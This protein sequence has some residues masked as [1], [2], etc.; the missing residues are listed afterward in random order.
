MITNLPYLLEVQACFILLWALFYAAIGRGSNFAFSRTYLL[1]LPVLSFVIP[2]LNIPVFVKYVY[3]GQVMPMGQL[4]A[5]FS[6]IMPVAEEMPR[7]GISF[8]DAAI[9]AATLGTIFFLFRFV[10]S[11]A[12]IRRM[13][14]KAKKITRNGI[15]LYDSDKCQSACSFFRNI[16]INTQ[17]MDP[18]YIDQIVAH[19]MTH[20][21]MR[22]SY[23]RVYAN[24]VHLLLWWNPVVWLWRRSLVEVHEY[25][26]D[27]KVL[28][29][30]YEKAQY[31]NL[32]IRELTDLH[33][34]F[35]SGFSYSLIKKRL[36]MISKRTS[37]RS[38]KLGILAAI[39]VVG[40]LMLLF[41]FTTRTEYINIV[42]NEKPS[43]RLESVEEGTGERKMYFRSL[44]DSTVSYNPATGERFLNVR[45]E[46]PREIL[47][48]KE[49][50]KLV[51]EV[52]GS[53]PQREASL[54]T[55]D[56][57]AFGD[58]IATL[59]RAKEKAL[60]NIDRHIQTVI[61]S[62]ADAEHIKAAVAEME[63]AKADISEQI[64]REQQQVMLQAEEHIRSSAE[65]QQSRKEMSNAQ[66]QPRTYVTE[67]Q[68]GTLRAAMADMDRQKEEMTRS[69]EQ[70][71]QDIISKAPNAEEAKKAAEEM[72]RAREEMNKS[73]E[74]ARQQMS[75]E[76]DG[77]LRF[78]VDESP[79]SHQKPSEVVRTA[80]VNTDQQ[81]RAVRAVNAA[82]DPQGEQTSQVNANDDRMT[83]KS[84]DS[85]QQQPQ[86]NQVVRD[87][88]KIVVVRN[89]NENSNQRAYRIVRDTD[90]D[91]QTNPQ[92]VPVLRVEEMPKF[93][94][95]GTSDFQKWVQARIKYPQEAV[96]NN[97][98]GAVTLSFVVNT[99]GEVVDVEVVSSPDSIL[100]EDAVRVVKSSPKWTPGMQRGKPQAVRLNIPILYEI[101]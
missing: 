83:V 44:S 27:R 36:T 40:G 78:T 64:S 23:D 25:Q 49:Y 46:E 3:L 37:G 58:A 71:R 47:T 54:N 13:S 1:L 39:P 34:E 85:G 16:Y 100:S 53:N 50:E 18:G 31:V 51:K 32:I 87:E 81:V 93:Q 7:N 74:E 62:N 63:K 98:Q 55:E 59:E 89:S 101:F 97:I 33:P 77:S 38:S 84:D 76:L 57:K 75:R 4:T 79:Y 66:E 11:L 5:E 70:M 22:H 15:S 52:T 41:S 60:E 48:N 86:T 56:V 26:V 10:L 90:I 43:I 30:G 42:E 21:E 95:G 94:G 2:L 61:S 29:R 19:E 45:G 14:H 65:M 24:I 12:V 9:A 80:N 28:D 69:F 82:P 96:N 73:F 92:D 17:D 20:V 99:A 6:E 8:R 72:D 67:S 35:V 68:K 88:D 91:Q